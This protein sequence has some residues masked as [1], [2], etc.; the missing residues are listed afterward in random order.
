MSPVASTSLPL[1]YLSPRGDTLIIAVRDEDALC[2]PS[3]LS[4][5]PYF[6]NFPSNPYYPLF[7][8]RWL[9]GVLSSCLKKFALVFRFP[10][11]DTPPL[12]RDPSFRFELFQS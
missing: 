5:S 7:S 6:S 4:F 3:L 10:E 1:L 8:L 12:S 9:V 11:R 2:S